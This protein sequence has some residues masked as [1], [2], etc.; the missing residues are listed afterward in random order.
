M[1]FIFLKII[2]K[3]K[4]MFLPS[5]IKKKFIKTNFKIFYSFFLNIS[6][7]FI[8]VKIIAIFEKKK[9]KI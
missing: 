2:Q 7:S 1:N 5:I 9:K 3:N 6:K 8:E 4:K